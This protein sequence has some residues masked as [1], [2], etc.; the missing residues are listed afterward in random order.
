MCN[1]QTAAPE[2]R[3]LCRRGVATHHRQ[4]QDCV[5]RL[6]TWCR[7]HNCVRRQR[8]PTS[9]PAAD[10]Q[11]HSLILAFL[12]CC[13][14]WKTAAGGRTAARLL[15]LLLLQL[16]DSLWIVV[17]VQA[18]QANREGEELKTQHNSQ[19]VDEKCRPTFAW[20]IE[21]AFLCCACYCCHRRSEFCVVSC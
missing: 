17:D 2:D 12:T 8:L 19:V 18:Q 5:G 14:C 20:S 16:P 13:V 4:T 7:C 21:P 15:P 6:H 3:R 10:K 11:F 9:K 1:Q